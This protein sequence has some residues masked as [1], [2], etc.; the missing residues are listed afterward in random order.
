MNHPSSSSSRFRQLARWW[1]V[2]LPLLGA[3]GNE[4]DITAAAPAAATARVSRDLVEGVPLGKPTAPV[5]IGFSLTA[6]PQPN[7][8]FKVR[9]VLTPSATVPAMTAEVTAGEGLVLL[10]PIA[11]VSF[12]KV[13]SGSTYEFTVT[14]QAPIAG[15]Q[16]INVA[17]TLTDPVSE[18]TRA[19]AFPVLVGGSAVPA[20]ATRAKP[21]AGGERVVP[22]KGTET[23]SP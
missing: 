2:S 3:C 9:V 4:P 15:G 16:V 10:D 17:V 13:S 22:L 11:P 23:T 19:V 1:L 14:A 12:E 7:V 18:Q 21:S 20:P 8:P 5:E 6:P